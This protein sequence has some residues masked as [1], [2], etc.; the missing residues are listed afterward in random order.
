MRT[1]LMSAIGTFEAVRAPYSGIASLALWA[2]LSIVS[3]ALGQEEPSTSRPAD[4]P[5]NAPATPRSEQQAEREAAFVKMLSGATLEGN[6]TNTSRVSDRTDLSREKYTLGEVKKLAGNIWL[7]QARIEY[8][9]HDVTLPITVPIQWAGDTP[10]IVVDNVGLPGFGTVSARVMFFA[11]HY[12]GYWKHGRSGGH[13][14]GVIRHP[15]NS[16]DDAAAPRDTA[17]PTEPAAG[18]A[19]RNR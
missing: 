10:V 1:E 4:V 13:L 18:S 5:A 7:I 19:D 11:D 15:E 2:V 16:G 14:F 9:E 17:T 6:F 3:T 12:A 8:G